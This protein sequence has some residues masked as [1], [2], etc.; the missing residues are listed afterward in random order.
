[1]SIRTVGAVF[2]FSVFN[3][4]NASHLFKL[5]KKEAKEEASPKARF[6]RRTKSVCN[7]QWSNYS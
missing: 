6:F 4:R 3:K 7:F 1:M 2:I 5:N